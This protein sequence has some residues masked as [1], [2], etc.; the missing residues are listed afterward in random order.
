MWGI[1]LQ[2]DG[3]M[4]LKRQ[5]YMALSERILNG[6]IKAGEAL[7]STR[8][9]AQ[10]LKISRN[11]V[12]EAYDMLAV[13]GFILNRP[14]SVARVA[15]GLVL[16]PLTPP[17]ESSREVR[18]A[19]VP[20]LADFRTGHPDL[21]LFPGIFGSSCRNGRCRKCRT[22]SLDTRDRKG[23]RGCAKKSPRI[24]SAAKAYTRLRRIFLLRRAPRMR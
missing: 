1:E 23:C 6:A 15:G 2:K 9:L 18:P 11:T 22:I 5:L 4:P 8:G 13:E 19:P 16:E 24:C 7:P 12:V 20:L 3:E 21:R 14:G 10:Q 17:A